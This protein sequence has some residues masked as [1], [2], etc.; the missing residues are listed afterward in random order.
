MINQ[1]FSNPA[2]QR[3]SRWGGL[4]GIAGGILLVAVFAIVALFVVAPAPEIA[5]TIMGFPDVQAAHMVEEVLY[6][7]VLALWAV[8]FVALDRVLRTTSLAPALFGKTV[9]VMGL[10]V[11]AAGALPQ[12]AK[13]PIS[14]LYHARGATPEDQA[15]LALLWQATTGMLDA[16]LVTGLLLLPLALL[17]FGAAMLRTPTFGKRYGWFS[18]TLGMAG[19]A[20]AVAAVGGADVAVIGILALIVFHLVVGWKLVRLS[21]ARSLPSVAATPIDAT[22]QVTA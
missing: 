20:A 19:T 9:S 15:T 2:E 13:A 16:L 21:G 11:L 3:V 18:V 17:M 4:A 1:A 7:G 10:V 14:S 8:H 12:V 22:M 6:L 5:Y